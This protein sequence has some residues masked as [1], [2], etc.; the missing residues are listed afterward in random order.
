MQLVKENGESKMTFRAQVIMRVENHKQ[1]NGNYSLVSP[2]VG[3]DSEN[4]QSLKLK[5]LKNIWR[6]HPAQENPTWSKLRDKLIN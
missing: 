6:R 4:Q 3:I 2:L 5:Y 1:S